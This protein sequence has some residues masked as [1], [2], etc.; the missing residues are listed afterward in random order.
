MKHHIIEQLIVGFVICLVWVS[1][2]FASLQR[3]TD[4]VSHHLA[5]AL[6]AYTYVRRFV[7]HFHAAW[8]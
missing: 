1:T 4:K 8:I 3:T 7:W 6:R 5:L 2:Y